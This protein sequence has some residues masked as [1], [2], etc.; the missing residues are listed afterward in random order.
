MTRAFLLTKTYMDVGI[1]T[2][3]PHALLDFGATAMGGGQG[4]IDIWD[5]GTGNRQGMG[6]QTAEFQTFIPTTNHFSWNSGGDLQT[7]GTNEL[8]RLTGNGYLGIGTNPGYKL[9]VAGVVNAQG[10]V[11]FPNGGTQ[12]TA[13]SPTAAA[14]DSVLT[15]SNGEIGIGT[16]NPTAPLQVVGAT[17]IPVKI[18]GDSNDTTNYWNGSILALW[19][20]D[21]TVNNFTGLAFQSNNGGY[22]TGFV[23]VQNKQ[24]SNNAPTAD[25]LFGTTNNGSLGEKMRISA[26]GN[27]GIGTT[28]PGATLEVNGNVKL[29]ANSGASITFQDGTTQ[30]TAYTGVTCGGDFAESVDVSGDRRHYEPGDLLVIDRK[31]PG[32]FLE[33]AAPYSTL[34]AGI[35]STKPGYVGRRPTGPKS[36]D[37]VPMAIVGIVPT[38]VTAENGPI[39]TGDLLVASSTPGHAMKGT[40]HGRLTGAVIGKALGNLDSGTGTIEVLV[41]LQ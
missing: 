7:S 40:D 20:T 2:T 34:V 37:E 3:S 15:Q 24:Q 13:Y 26:A 19:N 11:N 29:T 21:T 6:T 14:L 38:K 36:A 32:R 12:T 33:A 31:I 4:T 10:G 39:H 8:M 27:V 41:T 28:N 23:G 22:N 5:G 35:Y 18:A 17:G 30:S 1:G 9:D 25:I 16:P